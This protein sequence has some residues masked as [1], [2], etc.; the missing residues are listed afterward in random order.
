MYQNPQTTVWL[1]T[2]VKNNISIES[3]PQQQ[4]PTSETQQFHQHYKYQNPV[5]Q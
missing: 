1:L 3:K 2:N 5:H 4:Q